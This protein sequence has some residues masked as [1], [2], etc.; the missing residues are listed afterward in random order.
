M[1]ASSSAK[2]Y[3]SSQIL[4][5]ATENFSLNLPYHKIKMGI[6]IGIWHNCVFIEFTSIRILLCSSFYTII[7]LLDFTYSLIIF[8]IKDY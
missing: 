8:D 3:T 4:I 1:K 6:T 5:F 2:H 7:P